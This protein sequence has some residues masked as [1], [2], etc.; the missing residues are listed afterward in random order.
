V[1]SSPE[2]L[3]GLAGAQGAEMDFT[4]PVSS[5]TVDLPH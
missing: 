3:L 5:R 1:A 2:T 4:L